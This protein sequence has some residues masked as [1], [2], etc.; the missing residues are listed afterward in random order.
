MKKL[1]A[2]AIGVLLTVCYL[3]SEAQDQKIPLNE[4]DHN[5]PKLFNHLPQKMNLKLSEVESVFNYSVG[6]AIKLRVTDNL[7]FQG[8]VV[9]KSEDATVKS[10]V[11]K[12]SEL[13]GAIF[14][15]SRTTKEDGSFNYVGRIMSRN[16]G[17][18]Y[19]IK[20]EN[21]QYILQKKNLHELIAE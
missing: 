18:A 15:F 19:E 14:T 2:G 21:G 12:S 8:T 20:T 9:S 3:H 7:L 11:V 17:D 4:P 10:I 16:N 13:Q 6:T 1:K 5:K